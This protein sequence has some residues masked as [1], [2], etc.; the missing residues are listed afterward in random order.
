M[1][2][3]KRPDGFNDWARKHV[4]EDQSHWNREHN[5]EELHEDDWNV[6]EVNQMLEKDYVVDV[7]DPHGAPSSDPKTVYDLELDVGAHDQYESC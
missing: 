4:P 2:Y 3:R 7:D 6:E 5:A 1:E